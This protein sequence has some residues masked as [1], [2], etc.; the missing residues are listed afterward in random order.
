MK[1]E[2]RNE[3]T[4]ERFDRLMLEKKEVSGSLC[5]HDVKPGKRQTF[6]SSG[7][8]PS[9][10]LPFAPR[11]LNSNRKVGW[12]PPSSSPHPPHPPHTLHCITTMA[13]GPAATGP[14]IGGSG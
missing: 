1:E 6:G 13:G 12:N 3:K 7:Q 14:G 4:H 2:T 9:P 5:V 11:R 10:D 8:L